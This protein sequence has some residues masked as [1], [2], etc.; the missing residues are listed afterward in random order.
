MDDI[1]VKSKTRNY[2]SINYEFLAAKASY[3]NNN[4]KACDYIRKILQNVAD[5]SEYSW[6]PTI[7]YWRADDA[8]EGKIGYGEAVCRLADHWYAAL[9]TR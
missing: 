9:I 8:D 2:D 5:E 7:V 4:D 6:D 3:S 1:V